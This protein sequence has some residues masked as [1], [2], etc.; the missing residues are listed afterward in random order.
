MLLIKTTQFDSVP[1]LYHSTI[2][3][4]PCS[5]RADPITAAIRT[6]ALYT[7]SI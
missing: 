3:M 6:T 2:P 5:R 1:P 7:C 4:F